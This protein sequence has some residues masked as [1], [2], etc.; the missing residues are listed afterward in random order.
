MLEEIAREIATA[1]KH[2]RK[3]VAIHFQVLKNADQL[4]GMDAR[5]FCRKVGIEEAW[6]I[7]FKKMINLA[8]LLQE[9]GLELAP[10][11]A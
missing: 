3:A 9:Q 10:R 5:E 2:R 6:A 4:S 1:T 11:R 8:K 7:E